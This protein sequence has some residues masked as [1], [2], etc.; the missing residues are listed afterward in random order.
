MELTWVLAADSASARVFQWDGGQLRLL[1]EREHRASRDHN[2]DLM[3]NRPNQNQHSME[4]AIKGDEP[5]S[6][7]DDESRVFARELGELLSKAHALGQFQR[8]VLVADPRFL[9]MLRA[10]LTAPVARAVVGSMHKRGNDK[11]ADEVAEWVQ[12]HLQPPVA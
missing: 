4:T 9:G 12:P 11:S 2:Q 6:V 3:G 7:R 1:E 8:L 10:V 5:Q